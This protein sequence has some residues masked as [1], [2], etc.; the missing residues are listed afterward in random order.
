VATTTAAHPTTTPVASHDTNVRESTVTPVHTSNRVP[1][2]PATPT[3]IAL[4]NVIVDT[5]A[6]IDAPVKVVEKLLGGP[7]EIVAMGIGDIEEIPDGGESRTYLVGRYT[8]WVNYT[9]TGIAKGLM[10][11]DGLQNDG[12]SLDQWPLVLGRIGVGFVGSPDVVAPAARNWT[13]THGYAIMIVS[14][15]IGGTVATVRIYKIP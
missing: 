5:S 3:T 14:D 8:V 13:N 12:Y 9:K 10:V 7:T 6:V 1:T 15:S 11:E 4:K 2:P